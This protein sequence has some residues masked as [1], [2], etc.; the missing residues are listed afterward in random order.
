MS[1]GSREEHL[2]AA[3]VVPRPEYLRVGLTDA[4][5][6]AQATNDMVL[7]TDDLQVYLAATRAGI[8][9]ENFTHLREMYL[10]GG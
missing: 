10:Y 7:L 2:P 6:L 5:L 3:S 9:A 1:F 8:Q 4:A